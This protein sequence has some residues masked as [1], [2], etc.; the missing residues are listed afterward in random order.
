[1]SGR[2][3]RALL[4]AALAL[5]ALAGCVQQAAPA[6]AVIRTT[7]PPW[8]APRDGV[9]YFDLAGVPSSTLDDRSNQRV[10]NLSVELDGTRVPLAPNIGLDRPRAL[11]APA[12]THDD[13]GTVWLEGRGAQEVTLGQFFTLWGVRFD[14][15]CLGATCGRVEV[16]TDG[17]PVLDPGSLRL[18]DATDVQIRV[19]TGS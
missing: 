16:T 14:D 6:P 19:A 18:W 13:T 15:S 5:P 8:D 7:P 11:Q 9:S 12:H 2:L 17:R 4:V 3:A 10:V 1:M